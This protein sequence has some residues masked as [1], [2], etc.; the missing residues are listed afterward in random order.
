MQPKPQSLVIRNGNVLSADGRLRRLPVFIREGHI[1]AP[2]ADMP[3][4]REINA[5]GCY[6]VPGFIDIHT[7]GIGLD[8]AVGSLARYAEREA[9][10]GATT[11]LPTLF[12]P[13]DE[14]CA[15]LQRHLKETDNLRQTPQV[16]GFRLESPYLA[17]PSAGLPRDCASV[18]PS[19]TERLLEAGQGHIRIWDFSPELPGA[20]KAIA[21]LSRDGVVCSLAHTSATIEQARAAVDAGARLITHLFDTFTMPPMT[22]LGV[23]PAGLTDYLLLEDRV[24]CEIIPDGTHVPSLLVEKTFRCKPSHGLI[25]VTDS[26]YGAGLTPGEY[27]LPQAWG[28]VKI[29]GP[30][31]GIRL[32]E[33]G[34][35]LACSALTPVD[36]FCSAVQRFGKD[37]ATASRVCSRNP[38]KL[39]GLNKGEIAVGRD[40]D[41]VILDDVFQ[42]RYT[43]VA[44]VVAYQACPEAGEGADMA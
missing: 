13:P 24:A 41:L 10:A 39:L 6:V 30:Y 34:M 19:L 11:F 4:A 43:V 40:A 26:N 44:G 5:A 36:A 9:M 32:I 27:D 28:R 31:D 25:F 7:H 21:R 38:A 33:R 15:H 42:V 20:V 3:S 12:G 17:D 29:V 14:T 16:G 18:T 8:S 37:L 35:E 22:D 2:D 23:Y 1:V